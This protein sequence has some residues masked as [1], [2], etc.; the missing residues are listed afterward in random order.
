MESFK[1]KGN[2]ETNKT[3]SLKKK[4]EI[5]LE[6]VCEN[7][8]REFYAEAVRIKLSLP[9]NHPGRDLLISNLFDETIQKKIKRDLWKD[10]IQEKYK[11]CC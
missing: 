7:S 1:K 3:E 4:T 10:F 2:D 11:N 6:I 5:D 9:R 8:K